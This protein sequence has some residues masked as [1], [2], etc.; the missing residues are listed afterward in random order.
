MKNRD[1]V[2]A[3]ANK[4]KRNTIGDR[5]KMIHRSNAVYAL[6]ILFNKKY[7]GKSMKELSNIL[8]TNGV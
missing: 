5:E 1:G 3:I 4:L 8:T 6:N 7:N 2:S